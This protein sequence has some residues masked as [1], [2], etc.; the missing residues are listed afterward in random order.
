MCN[1]AKFIWE[2]MRSDEEVWAVRSE[3]VSCVRNIN[4]MTFSCVRG[5]GVGLG[6]EVREGQRYQLTVRL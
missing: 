2:E 1:E 3:D 4:Q 6:N 5:P